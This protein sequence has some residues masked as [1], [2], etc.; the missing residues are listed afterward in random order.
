[1]KKIIYIVLLV[2]M[3]VL[4]LTI[5]TNASKNNTENEGDKTASEIKFLESKIVDLLNK[6][7]G[8]EIRNYKISYGEMTKKTQ[9]Q[10]GGE[11]SKSAGSKSEEGEESSSGNGGSNEGDSS[12]SES[13]SNSDSQKG[14]KGTEQ[15]FE[16]KKTGVLSNNTEDI[17]WEEIKLDI[18]NLYSSIPTITVDLYR[19]NANQ[20]DILSFNKEYDNLMQV[21]KNEDK[22]KTLTQLSKLY[23]YIPKF[24]NNTSSTEIEKKVIE[25]KSNIL[26]GYSK[27]DNDN[28]NEIYSDVNNAIKGYSQLLSNT[29]IDSKKQYSINRIY[30]LLNELKSS[31]SLKDKQIFLIKYKNLLEEFDSL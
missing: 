26:K 9:E 21:A 10:S 15:K 6:M 24:I 27:L 25:A 19:N 8:I 31:I 14:T 5:Y 13:S 30:I 7:N 28:W 17:N 11:S 12:G 2:I 20:E 4:A 18:E 1:M 23:D 29:T 22:E 3:V 16:M